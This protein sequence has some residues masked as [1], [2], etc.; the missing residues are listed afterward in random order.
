MKM[1]ESENGQ[2]ENT[3]GCTTM[4]GWCVDNVIFFHWVLVL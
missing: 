2:K 1:N 4:D 3:Q